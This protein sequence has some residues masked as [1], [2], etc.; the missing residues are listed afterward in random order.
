MVAPTDFQLSGH[1]IHIGYSTIQSG[2]IR[3]NI[4]PPFVT[5]QDQTKSLSFS[6]D[7]VQTV[8]SEAGRLVSVVIVRTVD[9]GDTTFSFLVPT[10]NL[11]DQSVSSAPVHTV[12]ITTMHRT[13]LAPGLGQGQMDT[14][15]TI[16]LTGTASF[17][18]IH[19][20]LVETPA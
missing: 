18:R 14:F 13:G 11:P 6:G 16:A 5:Y 4:N 7:E 17:S 15:S 3:P 8:D 20:L 19:P 12:G 1:H 10:V 9:L 2:P